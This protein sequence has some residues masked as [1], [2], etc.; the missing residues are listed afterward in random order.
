MSA[1]TA[2]PEWAEGHGGAGRRWRGGKALIQ[3]QAASVWPSVIFP[4]G[5]PL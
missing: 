2:G 4:S 3:S 1:A 5:F